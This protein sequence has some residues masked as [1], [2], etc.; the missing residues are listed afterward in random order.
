LFDAPV[1]GLG[2]KFQGKKVEICKS[3][4]FFKKAITTKS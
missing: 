4:E 3:G 2:A 1:L